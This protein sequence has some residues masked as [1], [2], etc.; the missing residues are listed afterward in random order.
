MALRNNVDRRIL[1]DAAG[2]HHHDAARELGDHT[3]VVRDQ[4]HRHAELGAQ[5]AQQLEDLRLDG[6]VKRG[7]RLVGDQQARPAG[8]G[9]G[10]HHALAHAAGEAVRVLVDPA[11]GVGD[12]HQ[13]EQLDGALARLDARQPAMQ[14]HRLGD[15]VA[16]RQHGIE[17]GHRSLED[18]GDAA[19]DAR[20]PRSGAR[21]RS[22]RRSGSFPRENAR[23]CGRAGAGW[24]ARCA[25]RCRTADDT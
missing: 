3:Q 12:A 17:R 6:N 9:D 10:D 8:D 7:G 15:L 1:H 4:H 5:V 11:A 24:T 13:V 18:H 21:S 25:C 14:H 20:R 2:V 23:C 22:F 19:A 16:D